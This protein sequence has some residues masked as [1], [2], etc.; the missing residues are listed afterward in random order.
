M[1]EHLSLTDDEEQRITHM[2]SS[3]VSKHALGNSF[4]SSIPKA[5][6]VSNGFG[7]GGEGPGLEGAGQ[8]NSFSDGQLERHQSGTGSTTGPGSFTSDDSHDSQR[9]SA[10]GS[11]DDGASTVANEERERERHMQEM[12]EMRARHAKEIEDMKLRHVQEEQDCLEKQRTEKAERSEK[13][14]ERSTSDSTK[15]AAMQARMKDM[16]AKALQGL[17]STGIQKSNGIQ[18]ATANGYA[19]K[20]AHSNGNGN[21][22]MANG[23]SSTKS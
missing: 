8:R 6:S 5:H 1:V 23:V 4:A 7:N 15:A 2:I 12:K 21:G 9:D 17:G 18:K 19:N 14:L 3:E 20:A 16:E 13:L 10:N 11:G 22:V